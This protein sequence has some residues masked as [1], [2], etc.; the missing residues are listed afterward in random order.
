M[1]HLSLTWAC[2]LLFTVTLLS[3]SY[4]SMEFRGS[5]KTIPDPWLYRVILTTPYFAKPFLLFFDNEQWYRSLLKSIGDN[6][7]EEVDIPYV[8]DDGF[9][10]TLNLEQVKKLK[11]RP[12][13]SDITPD[14]MACL[15]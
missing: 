14:G 8:F 4:G 9:Y 7:S 2:A 11:E 10:A 5:C 15:Q 3:V 13:I 12:E 6:N 1:A